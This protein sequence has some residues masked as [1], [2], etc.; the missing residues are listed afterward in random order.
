MLFDK[1]FVSQKTMAMRGN[2]DCRDRSHA[3]ANKLAT[4][5]AFSAT[6]F[7]S[8]PES[9]SHLLFQTV[10]NS[11]SQLNTKHL[12]KQFNHQDSVKNESHC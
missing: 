2:G 11:K 7:V 9:G 5:T 3:P 1:G 4:S 6:R 12:E 8:L 10:P